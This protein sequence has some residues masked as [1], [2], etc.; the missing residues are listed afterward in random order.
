LLTKA[1]SL[2]ELL[3]CQTVRKPSFPHVP[4]H[5]PAHIHAL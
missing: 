5:K 4:A 1:A 2:G 3:L